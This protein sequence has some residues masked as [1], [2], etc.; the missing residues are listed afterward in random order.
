MDTFLI[1]QGCISHIS[2]EQASPFPSQSRNKD[3]KKTLILV[4]SRIC[5]EEQIRELEDK[6]MEMTCEEQNKVK[7]MKRAED[8][9]RDLWDHIKCT[10]IRIIGVP[11]EEKKKGY[12][13]IFEEIVVENFHNMEK[14]IVNQVQEAQSPTYRINPRRNMPRHILIKLTKTKHKE[15]ILQAARDK[16]QVTY[17]GDPIVSSSLKFS[18][19]F[20]SLSWAACVSGVSGTWRPCVHLST[21]AGFW[22]VHLWGF[23]WLVFSR[24]HL[25]CLGSFASVSATVFV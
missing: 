11:E 4:Y 9:L 13:K 20:F 24:H 19:W 2:W 25:L 8:S 14:E 5:E 3:S 17:Q 23:F 7:R 15:R 10:N 21:F 12:T 6:M 16:R 1:P 22:G 18:I